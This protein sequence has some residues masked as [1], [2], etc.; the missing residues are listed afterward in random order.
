[1][2]YVEL[3]AGRPLE[4][5]LP[6]VSNR[7]LGLLALEPVRL[8]LATVLADALGQLACRSQLAR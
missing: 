3:T 4:E 8:L 1:M 6:Q 5:I 2:I 7:G